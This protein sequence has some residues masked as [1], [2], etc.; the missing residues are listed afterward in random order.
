MSCLSRSPDAYLTVAT[1]E[2][3]ATEGG[4]VSTAGPAQEE[5]EVLRVQLRLAE[6]TAQRVQREVPPTHTHTHLTFDPMSG[7]VA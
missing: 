5:L 4:C 1:G 2:G 3:V 6:E 7:G